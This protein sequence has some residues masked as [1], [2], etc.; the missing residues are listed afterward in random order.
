[1]EKNN[2]FKYHDQIGHLGVKKTV[3]IILQNYWFPNLTFKVKQH[4][5]HC[6]KYIAY[7]SLSGKTEGILYSVP[8]GKVPLNTL[9]VDYLS[10][11]DNSA[12]LRNIFL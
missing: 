10:P 9:H 11:L 1:M 3:C 4:I 12:Y 8:K 5:A 2:L 6:L 7:S